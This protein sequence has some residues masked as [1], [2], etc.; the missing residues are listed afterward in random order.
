MHIL[1]TNNSCNNNCIYCNKLNYKNH[2][3]PSINEIINHLY[4]LKNKNIKKITFPCNTEFR[5]DFFDLLYETKKLN[6]QI[7]LL[8]NARFFYY[9][10]NCLEALKYIKYFECFININKKLNNTITKSKLFLESIQG[11]KN[12]IKLKAKIKIL[13]IIKITNMLLKDFTKKG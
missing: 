12:L 13:I 4:Q 8:T 2:I 7:T 3:Y 11:I 6:F 1:K 5:T 10:N 9:L